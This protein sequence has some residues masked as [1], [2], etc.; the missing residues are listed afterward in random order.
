MKVWFTQDNCRLLWPQ[1][2]ALWN[3]LKFSE[4][5]HKLLAFKCRVSIQY[6]IRS[7]KNLRFMCG[8]LWV[9]RRTLSQPHSYKAYFS[10]YRNLFLYFDKHDIGF[11][12]MEY[13]INRVL[14]IVC[15]YYVRMSLF[16]AKSISF[17]VWKK[18]DLFVSRRMK[19]SSISRSF[20][21]H[22]FARKRKYFDKKDIFVTIIV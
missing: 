9:D 20:E 2:F 3:I 16:D 7:F 8:Q 4:F 17:F 18:V 15:P 5:T 21:G 6:L 10:D 22:R 13:S 14:H 1:T 11:G 12:I 19:R